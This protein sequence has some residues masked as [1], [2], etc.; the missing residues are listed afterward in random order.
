MVAATNNTD[1]SLLEPLLALTVDPDVKTARML[2]QALAKHPTE[3]AVAALGRL[4]ERGGEV[5]VFAASMLGVNKSP[6]AVPALV[7]L[8][9]HS[10]VGIRITAINGLC[11]SPKPSPATIEALIRMADDPDPK[12]V[13]ALKFEVF[14]YSL[15]LTDEQREKLK[16]IGQ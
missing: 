7:S 9:V 3:S 2:C 13:H 15:P 6:A 4:A 5:S 1:S 12:V 16:K 8:L 10:E 14:N 11:R